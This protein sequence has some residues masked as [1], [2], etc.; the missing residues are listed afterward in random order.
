MS[1]INPM[2]MTYLLTGLTV[3]FGHC[4]GMCGPLVISFSLSRKNNGFYLPHL[5][6]HC[7]RTI[8]YALLGAA[9]GATGSFTMVAGQIASFQKGILFL[10][11]G[12]MIAM[13]LAMGGWL[14]RFRIFHA[15]ATVAGFFARTF[16]K[17]A[18][19]RSTIAYLPLGLL[20]GLLPCGPVYTALLGS[21]RAGMEATD[22][23]QGAA[24]GAAMMTAFG[25]GTVPALFLVAK[26]ADLGW[27]RFRDKIYKAGAL[28]MIGVG[29]YFLYSAFTY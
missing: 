7:G 18:H 11:S 1:S 6:Y 4:I 26:L 19:T 28:L 10:A 12:V 16:K 22:A 23:C 25:L 29:L 3:G 13:G 9:I 27:L 2:I 24:A 8:T 5:F 15:D 17:L 20:L 14:P 21:A